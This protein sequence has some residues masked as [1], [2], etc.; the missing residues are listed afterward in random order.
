MGKHSFCSPGLQQKPNIF[1]LDQLK[2][3]PKV[4]WQYNY[5]QATELFVFLEENLLPRQNEQQNR[6]RA[7]NIFLWNC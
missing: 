1:T 6:K 3:L 7:K 2:S 5:I 4:N